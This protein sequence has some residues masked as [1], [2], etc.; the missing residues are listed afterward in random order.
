MKNIL[1]ALFVLLAYQSSGQ[2]VHFTQYASS[3][4]TLNPANTGLINSDWR[5]ATNYR[6]QWSGIGE[7]YLTTTLSYDM[8]LLKGKLN[9][10]SLGVGILGLYDQ[11]GSATLLNKT[12]GLSVA[13]HQKLNSDANKPSVL[14]FGA[15]AY[16]VDKSIDLEKLVFAGPEPLN[17]GVMDPYPDFNIGLM[18]TG[19]IGQHSSIYSGVSY[20]HV[21][22][23]VESFLGDD[24]K[25]N[26]RFAMHIG[27][28][29]KLNDRF[30]F[31]GSALYQQQGQAYE[32]VLGSAVGIS[33][34]AL[35]E[36]T[37]KN[38]TLFVGTWYRYGDAIA[39]YVGFEWYK[40]R[41]GFSYD[42]YLQENN[43]IGKTAGGSLELSL[44][45][46]GG[47]SKNGLNNSN[48]A[49]PRF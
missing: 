5:G 40:T 1:I 14:S 4:L 30:Q 29:Y 27:G 32:I 48:F 37:R 2:D 38:A 25:I 34:N 3:P 16:L 45:Y 41:L 33:L 7:P 19:Y 31:V 26:S 49:C 13:Y 17:P 20:Y 42:T 35:Q 43:G 39:P 9:G 6:N 23:P 12:F 44:I 15:Q 8:S 18:Y 10:N 28:T 11:S 21:T 22:R 24:Y 47:F 46:N 36:D